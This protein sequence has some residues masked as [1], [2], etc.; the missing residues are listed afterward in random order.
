MDNLTFF[1]AYIIITVH[2]GIVLR[3]ARLIK[4][5]SLR[6]QKSSAEPLT[7]V[8]HILGSGCSLLR[9]YLIHLLL[10]EPGIGGSSTPSMVGAVKKWQ[11]SDPQKSLD[12]WK[13]LSEA[14]SQ[15][16]I[17]LNFLSK[18]AKEQWDAYK[19]V[20][21]SCNKLRLEKWIEQAS[22]P[23]KEA[24]IKVLLGAKEAMLRIRYHM[25]LMGEA[26]GV[27]IEP[28]SQIK[29]LDATLNL[30]GVLLAGVPRA[31]GF[32]AVFAITLGDSSSNVTKA[33]SSLNVLAL[34][35]KEDPCGVSLESA[36]P[37]T[38]KI[39]SAISLIHIE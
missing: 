34:L 35:V 28:E 16:K 32:D 22:E 2:L 38:N 25:R 6:E 7:P 5:G 30:E 18:L 15:L 37:R 3:M 14:N 12:T 10:G 33:W 4:D 19:Y 1:P 39:T 24:V 31:G 13:R 26:A 23:N 29:L 36:N 20:I 27:P 8:N 21:D 9:H 11:K 17:Q